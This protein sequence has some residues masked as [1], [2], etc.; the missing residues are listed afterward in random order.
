MRSAEGESGCGGSEKPGA[1]SGA[2]TFTDE[3][4]RLTSDAAQMGAIRCRRGSR[5]AKG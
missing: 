1:G 5:V 4:S 3:V 2:F